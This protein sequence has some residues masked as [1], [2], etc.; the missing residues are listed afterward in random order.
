MYLEEPL[1]IVADGPDGCGKTTL[2][3]NL[4]RHLREDL[5]QEVVVMKGL[6]QGRIG[7]ECRIRHLT[8][9]T[10]PGFESLIIPISFM[11]AYYDH[12]L[13]ALAEGKSVLMD[14]WV[15]C[16]FAYQVNGREDLYAKEIYET[17]FDRNR[18]PMVRQPNIYFLGYVDRLVADQRLKAR[19][20]HINYLDQ[21][22][23]EFKDRV[24][25]GYAKFAKQNTGTVQLNCNLSEATVF[26]TAKAQIEL[27]L[28]K[29]RDAQM[30]ERRR[31]ANKLQKEAQA[32]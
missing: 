11:E 12:V 18:T 6:G 26:M 5:K 32:Q 14:R 17:L 30:A 21:E 23:T 27:Y 8:S 13:P 24:V 4:A 3:N 1:F 9:Q 20:E 10:G 19:P 16:F 28:S 31:I 29:Q 7:A 22:T 15:A 25:Q 2:I